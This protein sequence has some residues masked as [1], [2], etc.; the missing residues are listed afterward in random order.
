MGRVF[1]NIVTARYRVN[2]RN[3]GKFLGFNL[4]TH[5]ADGFNFRPDE[6]N[7]LGFKLFTKGGIL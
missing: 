1:D 2:P 4:V 3:T 6:G 5:D 7:A